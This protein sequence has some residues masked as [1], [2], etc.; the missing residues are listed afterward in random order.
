[1]SGTDT[2]AVVELTASEARN[3][4]LAARKEGRD[5]DTDA[6]KELSRAFGDDDDGP[7]DYPSGTM[8]FMADAEGLCDIATKAQIH[9]R[10]RREKGHNASQSKYYSIG[11]KMESQLVKQGAWVETHE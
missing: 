3:A 5:T 10:E 6:M 11:D 2:T 7:E 1:M 8:R 9:G 4:R